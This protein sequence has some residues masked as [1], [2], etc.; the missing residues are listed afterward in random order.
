LKIRF[1]EYKDLEDIISI[2]NQAIKAE[3]ATADIKELNINDREN[4]FFEHNNDKYP[5][6]LIEL[7][8][9]IIGWGSISPS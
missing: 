3:N 7:K 8:N 6:Y 4:W 2:Y 9:T 5:I 1:A